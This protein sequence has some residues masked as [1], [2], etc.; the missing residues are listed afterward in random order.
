M[1][2]KPDFQF[3]AIADVQKSRREAIK[4]VA[5]KR[6]GNTDCV[7]YR[8][9]MEIIN[10]RDIDAVVIA[11]GDRWHTVASILAAKAGKDVYCEKP[12]SL[13]IGETKE[14]A[15]GMNR[16]GRVF[17]AGTQRRGQGSFR[18]AVHLARSGMLGR[19]HTVYA[20]ITQLTHKTGSLPAQ[21]EP[22]KDECDWDFWLGP[23]PWRPY[24]KAYLTRWTGYHDFTATAHLLDFGSHTVDMCQWALDKDGTTPLTYEAEPDGKT[25]YAHYKDGVELVIRD[26]RTKGF[27]L[28]L[29]PC[30]VRFEGDQGW[31]E[32]GDNGIATN[33]KSLLKELTTFAQSDRAVSPNDHV[34]DFIECIK[35][36]G[37]TECNPDVM[38]SSHLA[39]HAAGMSWL[40][41]RKLTF[42]P[43]RET[44]IGDDQANRM[45]IRAK[46]AAWCV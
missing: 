41:G 45:C 15:D 9:M 4:K 25:V 12:C 27:W 11:T 1:M 19:I 21:P 35:S 44:F 28:D 16:L 18:F 36:R 10:R 26:W 24:N 38:R 5:D 43:V 37:K 32:V 7:M 6:Y 34:R 20:A 46:R 39:C 14:L 2:N 33:P 23:A 30:P 40:L 8:D 22:P 31:V 42:D 13:T 3:V 29:G 17:Q